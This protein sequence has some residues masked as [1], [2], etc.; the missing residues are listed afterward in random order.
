MKIFFK[1]TKEKRNY[2]LL[3]K[4]KVNSANDYLKLSEIHQKLKKDFFI[5]GI[6]II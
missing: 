4:Y 2:K 3:D 1:I 6:I 5:G